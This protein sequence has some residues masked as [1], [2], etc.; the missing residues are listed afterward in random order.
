MTH[1]KTRSVRLN[2]DGE[3]LD[4]ARKTGRGPKATLIVS[5]VLAV[6]GVLSIIA[7]ILVLLV[8]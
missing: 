4:D 8:K 1:L 2:E 5:I 7:A 3:H 6:V